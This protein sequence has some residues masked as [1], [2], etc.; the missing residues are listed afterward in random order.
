MTLKAPRS[1]QTREAEI[2]SSEVF[3]AEE[4]RVAPFSKEDKSP[5]SS[6]LLALLTFFH[7]LTGLDGDR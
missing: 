7:N 1:L 6:V 4:K 2:L 5:V 3:N